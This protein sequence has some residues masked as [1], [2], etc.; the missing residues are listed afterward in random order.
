[1]KAEHK[2]AR[3]RLSVLDLALEMDN[4]SE[5]CRRRGVSRTQFYE[6]KRRFQTHGIE[7]LKDLPPV[8]KSHPMATPEEVQEKIVALS[9]SHPAWGCNRVSDQLKLEGISVSAPTVQNILNKEGLGTRYERWLK[10][11][12]KT[13]E[14]E[15]ELSAEQVAFIE[16]QNPCFRERHVESSRPG[17]LLITRTPSSWGTLKGW[18]RSTYTPWWTPTRAWRLASCTSLSSR[19][20]RWPCCTTRCCRSTPRGAW[21]LRACSPT[22]V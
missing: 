7:G 9:L 11:E 16:K 21:R 17:E 10:L 3:Q 5:A 19:R 2:L 4:V 13:A 8:Q 14:N 15:I 12:E 1:M 6:Y 20:P 18:A 22:M